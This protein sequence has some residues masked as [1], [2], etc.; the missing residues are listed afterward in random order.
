MSADLLSHYYRL[1]AENKEKIKRLNEAKTK[2]SEYKE[3][4]AGHYNLFYQPELSDDTWSGQL[5]E[6]FETI[7]KSLQVSYNELKGTKFTNIFISITAKISE[8]QIQIV[9]YQNCIEAIL[10]AMREEEN[11]KI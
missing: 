7:R 11:T 4:L 1:I 8:L 10:A 3:E 2:L 9:Y 5:A 6:G